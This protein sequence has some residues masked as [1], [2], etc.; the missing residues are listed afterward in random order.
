MNPTHP[1]F[2]HLP[3]LREEFPEKFRSRF[4]N[5]GRYVMSGIEAFFKRSCKNVLQ[6]MEILVR[7]RRAR[8]S[9]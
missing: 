5:K 6:T 9:F 7:L 1:T 2:H 3:K 4:V 8:S